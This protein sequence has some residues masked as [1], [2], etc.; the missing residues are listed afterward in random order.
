MASALPL[1]RRLAL[2]AGWPPSAWE[3][4]DLSRDPDQLHNIA[5]SLPAA[6]RASLRTRPTR[7]STCAGAAS[8]W[9]A[10]RAPQP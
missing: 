8:C 6:T 1:T 7:M 5:G 9:S 2:G 4:D 10:A 3:H